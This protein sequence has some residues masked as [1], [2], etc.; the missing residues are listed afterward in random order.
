MD[1]KISELPAASSITSDDLIPIVDDPNGTPVTQKATA[2][3][4]AAFIGS[5]S[6]VGQVYQ[7][8]APA[9]PD[10]LTRPALDYPVGGGSLQQWDVPSQLWV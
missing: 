5:A 2:A 8:R 10:D 6:G 9:A 4:L 1:K 7:G 3:Q